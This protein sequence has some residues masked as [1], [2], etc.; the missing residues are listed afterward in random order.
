MKIH[1]IVVFTLFLSGVLTS[2]G[3]SKAYEPV[4]VV[5]NALYRDIPLDSA[6]IAQITWQ[7]FFSDVHLQELLEL[8][9][10]RNLDLKIGLE[11]MHS[12]SAL[13]K[14]AKANFLPSVAVGAG[15]KQSR[16]SENQSFG[17]MKNATAYDLFATMSWEVDVWGKLASS[18]RAAFY[19]LLQT[20]ETQ[21]A[22]K[23]QLISQ[24]ADYYYQLVALDRQQVILEQTIGNRAEDVKT[25]QR[26]KESSVVTGAAVVQ[27]EANYY[28]A[29]ADLPNVKRQIRTIEHALQVLIDSSG[30]VIPRGNFDSQRMEQ[31]ITVGLPVQL[32]ANRPDVKAAEM[33]VASYF[34]EVHVAR[35]AFYPALTLTGGTGYSTYEFKEWFSTT[36]FFANIAGGL[37]QPLFNKRLNKT[38]LEI[39]KANYQ[40]K[41]YHFE[42][43]LLVAG[44][45]VS[46]AL[47]SYQTANEQ[48]EKRALQVE[49]LSLAVDYT[50]KLL[51]YHSSTNYTD[52]LTSEQ[53]YLNAQIQQTKDWLL[54]W[55]STIKLYRALGGGAK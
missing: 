46:D 48:E 5:P 22:V 29:Q 53:A 42:K 47:Y 27:S 26:L 19:K 14:Q 41:V 35:R 55:Q 11:R 6:S 2:C 8:G 18:K 39:A 23:T 30:A 38:R 31:S 43:A 9:L 50:K 15:M 25:M 13:L 12:A 7:D 34:E 44:Q 20:N 54:K 49:K 28:A 1:T 51:L 10:A 36:G 37:V 16:M 45:E 21:Q 4:K 32:L 33:E 3:T 52:V 24:I 17:Q 40:E